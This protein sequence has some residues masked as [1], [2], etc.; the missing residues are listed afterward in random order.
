M[1]K[2]LVDQGADMVEK[3]VFNNTP[4]HNAC[5]YGNL[6][7][8]KYLVEQGADKKAKNEYNKTPLHNAYRNGNLDIVKYLYEKISSINFLFLF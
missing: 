1:V 5:Y 3:C 6:D 7:V 8:V 2:C 4:F